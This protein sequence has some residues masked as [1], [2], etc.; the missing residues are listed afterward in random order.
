MNGI[1]IEM[2]RRRGK[3]LFHMT[4]VLEAAIDAEAFELGRLCS[5]IAKVTCELERAVPVGERVFSLVRVFD[6]E[7][8]AFER[9]A[10][11]NQHVRSVEML[12]DHDGEALYSIE[13]DDERD[14]FIEAIRATDG[15]VL[16]GH[17]RDAETWQFEL[18]FPDRDR[19]S[20]FHDRLLEVGTTFEVRSIGDPVRGES[21]EALSEPQHEA[22]LRAI[23]EGYYDI[24]RQVSASELADEFDISDQAMSERLRR[25]ITGLGRTTFRELDK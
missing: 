8:D 4:V 7:D 11:S 19:L 1:N 25:A 18:L 5:G 13:W 15:H 2:T 20:A 10:A 17:C 22:L 6:W 21:G 9:A 16:E 3:S 23:E 14:A 24:P 12:E